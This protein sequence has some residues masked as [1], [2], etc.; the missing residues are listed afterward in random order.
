MH[1]SILEAY[2]F[3]KKKKKN[4]SK[5]NKQHIMPGILSKLSPYITS[6]TFSLW[7]TTWFQFPCLQPQIRILCLVDL[8]TNISGMGN[9]TD[10]SPM[11]VN[12]VRQCKRMRGGALMALGT[13][14]VAV[15]MGGSVWYSKGGGAGEENT[16][17]EVI[18]GRGGEMKRMGV[19]KK[20]RSRSST[21]WD[22]MT[23]NYYNSLW[24]EVGENIWSR[25]FEASRL[26]PEEC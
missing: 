20:S 7:E 10:F 26:E 4:H 9:P 19:K 8:Y 18:G 1:C 16:S 14:P 12:L 2:I 3:K 21:V 6:H 25:H 17:R 22:C 11:S 23:Q 13:R 5:P 24:L 15:G